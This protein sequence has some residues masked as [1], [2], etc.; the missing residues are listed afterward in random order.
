MTTDTGDL[1]DA[2]AS[3]T[4]SSWQ[5]VAQNIAPTRRTVRPVWELLWLGMKSQPWGIAAGLLA[6][7]TALPLAILGAAVGAIA[8]A[9][10]GALAGFQQSGGTFSPYYSGLSGGLN[11]FAIIGA[12]GAGALAGFLYVYG[13]SWVSAPGHVLASLISGAVV[14]V[15]LTALIILRERWWLRLYGYRRMSWEEKEQVEPLLKGAAAAMAIDLETGPRIMMS[16][17]KQPGAWAHCT[18]IVLTTGTLALHTDQE[19]AGTLVHELQH[20]E[21]GTAVGLQLVWASVWPLILI[22]NLLQRLMRSRHPVITVVA[23]LLGWP[24]LIVL[25]FFVAPVQ[26][27][28]GR[29]HEYTADAAATA[30]GPYYR[31]GLKSALAV[32]GA[33]LEPGR[34]GWEKTIA[35]THPPTALRIERLISQEEAG[36]RA[37]VLARGG[38]P[39]WWRDR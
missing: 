30:A 27:L 13:G 24:I 28:R 18:T 38:V 37:E 33:A 8:G 16:D 19:I 20:W 32:V 26:Q 4:P 39:R 14:M 34:T 15:G 3:A 6:A 35:A 25:N 1:R 7:Y 12:A 36:Q 31:E 11:F 21:D 22:F 17:K 9:I 29:G 23:L 5:R 2:G 10:A